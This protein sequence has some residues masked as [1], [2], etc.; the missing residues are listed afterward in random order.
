MSKNFSQRQPLVQP[1]LLTKKEL[2]LVKGR[3]ERVIA[4][5]RISQ[6]SKNISKK[7]L[8]R[9]LALLNS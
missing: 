6:E 3:C 1:L 5:K 8:V 9:V 4:D 7:T 2:Q